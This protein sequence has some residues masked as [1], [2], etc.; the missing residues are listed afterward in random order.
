MSYDDYIED[1]D[2]F[3]ERFGDH[4]QQGFSETFMRPQPVDPSTTAAVA[5]YSSNCPVCGGGLIGDGFT[6][7]IHCENVDVIGEGYEPDADPVYCDP[8]LEVVRNENIH[9]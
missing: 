3:N 6:S 7:V 4:H 1:R 5:R 9:T 2:E 8:N